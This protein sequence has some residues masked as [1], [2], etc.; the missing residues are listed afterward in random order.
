M[1][2]ALTEPAKVVDGGDDSP[3]EQ[4]M[5]HTVDQH[6]GKQRVLW[7]GHGI[8]QLSSTTALR[9]CDWLR[10]GKAFQKATRNDA[11]RCLMLA[12]Q[13]EVLIHCVAFHHRWRRSRFP[14]NPAKERLTLR[15]ILV[16]HGANGRS[17]LALF[18]RK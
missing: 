1:G 11:F 18:P 7:I 5:P 16:D 3:S 17:P 4:M 6:T 14:L 15:E 2:G 10:T 13:K 8:R 9:T 12:A